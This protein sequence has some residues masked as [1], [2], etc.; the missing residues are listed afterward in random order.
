MGQGV[1]RFQSYTIVC[2]F[3]YGWP[4]PPVPSEVLAATACPVPT[5]CQNLASSSSVQPP[6]EDQ[7]QSLGCFSLPVPHVHLVLRGMH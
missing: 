3:E 1:T 2:G 5:Q 6:A 4:C 7:Y